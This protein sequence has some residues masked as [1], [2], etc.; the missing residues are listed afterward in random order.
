MF[1]IDWHDYA[2]PQEAAVE[3]PLTDCILQ[4]NELENLQMA[5]NP[6]AECDDLGVG[7]YAATKQFVQLCIAQRQ[8]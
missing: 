6:M 5:I 1:G 2:V 7:L 4:P 3:V 8:N